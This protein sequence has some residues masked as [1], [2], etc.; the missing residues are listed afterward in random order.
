M[1]KLTVVNKTI[2]YYDL[3]FNF[4]N[5][6]R[7]N[8][9]DLFREFFQIIVS[10]SKTKAPI[11]YQLFGEKSIFI[12]D[13]KFLPHTKQISGKLRCIRTDVLP[14]IMNTKTDEARGIDALDEEGLVETTHFILD[15]SKKNKKIAIEY[16]QFGAKINDFVLYVQNIGVNKKVIK[17]VGYI[18]IIKN[19]LSKYAKRI[20]RT[21]EFI[22][23]IHKDNIDAV[24]KVDSGIYSAAK[25]ALDQFQSDYALLNLKFDYT[26]KTATV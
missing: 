22:V 3:D 8:D 13:I 10:L 12:Q 18:P 16:N 25:A 7:A 6:F 9:G 1:N 5:T 19:E 24:K 15:Y 21:S 26:K 4:L 17:T 11:R 23:K 20:N 14:E 2:H